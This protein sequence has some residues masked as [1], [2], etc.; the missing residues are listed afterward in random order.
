MMSFSTCARVGTATGIVGGLVS[1]AFFLG[2]AKRAD[3][4]G[5]PL[6]FAM[7]IYSAAF[8]LGGPIVG[9][10]G[11]VGYYGLKRGVKYLRGAPRSTQVLVLTVLGSATAITGAYKL[12]EGER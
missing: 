6:T 10:G 9:A 3:R 12:G 7:A 5:S 4:K 2:A 8:F 11:G 1:S